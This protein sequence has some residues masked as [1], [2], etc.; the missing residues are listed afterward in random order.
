MKNKMTVEK[1]GI[2]FSL[3]TKI[4]PPEII[5]K[6]C[7]VFID[8][9]YIYLDDPKKGEIQVRLKGK[10]DLN[11]KDLEKL[12]GEFSNELLNTILRESVAKR[13][14][15]VL[16]YIVGGAINASLE[17]AAPEE[18]LENPEDLDIEREIAAIKKELE[19]MDG[20]DY[21]NDSLGIRKLAAPR[22][23]N[24]KK[25]ARPGRK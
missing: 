20:A 1:D 12:K 17:K 16:E 10:K 2:V 18:R 9:M 13:N 5:Y 23:K 7:Y 14:Q 24:K 6:T 15:K 11:A 21:K 4:Y 25:P 19:A 3:R 22:K 8:R